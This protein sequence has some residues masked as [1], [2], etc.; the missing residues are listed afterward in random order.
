LLAK[1]RREPE[2]PRERNSGP[3]PRLRHLRL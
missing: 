3:R 2:P 1:T